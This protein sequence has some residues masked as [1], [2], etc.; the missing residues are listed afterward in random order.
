MLYLYLV[1]AGFA[2]TFIAFTLAAGADADVGDSE[3]GQSAGD[4]ASTHPHDASH[5]HPGAFAPWLADAS[6]SWLPLTSLRFWTFAVAFFGMAG[7]ALTWL[8]GTGAVLTLVLAV[9]VGWVTGIVAS[10][11]TH[12]LAVR[13]SSSQVGDGDLEGASGLVV[14]GLA[15]GQIGKIRVDAKGRTFDVLAQTDDEA[16][17]AAGT[18]VLIVSMAGGRAMVAALAASE[19]EG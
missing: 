6:F 16:P 15:K 10:W 13:E 2:G 4:P 3:L 8:A 12:V 1:A 7:A 18:Q 5:G 9:T 14:V 19:G 11:F 17:L